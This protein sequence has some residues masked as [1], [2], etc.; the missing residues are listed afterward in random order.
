MGTRKGIEPI[1]VEIGFVSQKEFNY[2]AID[3]RT[4][5]PLGA[6]AS[7]LICT[8]SLALLCEHPCRLGYERTPRGA[9][10]DS[11]VVFKPLTALNPVLPVLSYGKIGGCGQ[12]QLSGR[13]KRLRNRRIVTPG[14][15]FGLGV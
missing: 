9:D 8:R 10:N 5:T 12:T 1:L 15:G 11:T 7:T 4:S 14:M 13:G 3:A 6:S 2:A